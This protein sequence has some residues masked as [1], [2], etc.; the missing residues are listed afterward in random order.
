MARRLDDLPTL[1]VTLA[2]LH[3]TQWVPHRRQARLET[4]VELE[5]TARAAVDVDQAVEAVLLQ[6]VGPVGGGR[7]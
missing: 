4:A 5:R 7:S 3:D 2:A 1:T 6:A